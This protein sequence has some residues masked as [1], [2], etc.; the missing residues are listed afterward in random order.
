MRRIYP[1]RAPAIYGTYGPRV[2]M[3]LGIVALWGLTGAS[4]RER[5]ALG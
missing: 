3:A 1:L 5:Q 2:G 4:S